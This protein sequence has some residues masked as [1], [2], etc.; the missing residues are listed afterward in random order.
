MIT[1][2]PPTLDQVFENLKQAA[3]QADLKN[4]VATFAAE[5]LRVTVGGIITLLGMAG[6]GYTVMMW[7]A[8]SFGPMEP[9]T[10]LRIVVP[11]GVC[12]TLG[13]QIV[14]SSFFLSILGLKRRRDAPGSNR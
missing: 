14:L 8:R 2:E 12:L 6:A 13:Y 9:G 10:L 7:T 11:S 1:N 4:R 5:I 3:L